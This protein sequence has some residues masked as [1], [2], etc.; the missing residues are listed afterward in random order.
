[1][2]VAGE[3]GEWSVRAKIAGTH[4]ICFENKNGKEKLLLSFDITTGEGMT[5]EFARKG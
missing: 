2:C 5:E 3:Q 4:R 1:M